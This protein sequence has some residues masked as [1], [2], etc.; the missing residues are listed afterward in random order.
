MPTYYN[1]QNITRAGTNQLSNNYYITKVILTVIFNNKSVFF[2]YPTALCT[3]VKPNFGRS[4]LQP[5]NVDHLNRTNQSRTLLV[6]PSVIR[7]DN[8]VNN[9]LAL[10][11]S[12]QPSILQFACKRRIEQC[13][14]CDLSRVFIHIVNTKLIL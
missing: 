5:I 14:H 13:P 3:S 7:T 9:A 8:Y 6:A 12:L 1:S 11:M 4:K 2:V 10:P